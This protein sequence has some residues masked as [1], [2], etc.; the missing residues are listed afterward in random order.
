[1]ATNNY[2]WPPKGA[3]QPIDGKKIGRILLIAA[4]SI[5]V[6]I[7]IVTCFYTVDDKQQAVV[8]TSVKSPA[9][10]SPACT[11]SCPSASRRP[12]GWM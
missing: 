12:S 2:Q 4:I 7:G 9:P 6:I 3:G 8:T 1:M 11:S 10:P 5:F